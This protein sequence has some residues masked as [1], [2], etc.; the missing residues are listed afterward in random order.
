MVIKLMTSEFYAAIA[1]LICM[2]GYKWALN[3][4][5]PLLSALPIA[6]DDLVFQIT[7]CRNRTR[8]DAIFDVS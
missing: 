1:G 3:M 5:R 4:Y 6:V 8:K 2:G 7:F